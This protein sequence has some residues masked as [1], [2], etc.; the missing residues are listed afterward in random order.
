MKYRLSLVSAL[1]LAGALFAATQKSFDKPLSK[2]QKVEHALNRLT[3]GARPGDVEAIKR[4]GVDK[5]IQQQLHPEKIAENPELL[6]RLEQLP[7]LTMSS[8][9]AADR[10]EVPL[11][12]LQALQNASD[13]AKQKTKQQLKQQG[14]GPQV[15]GRELT[16]AKLLRAIYSERQL[17]ELMVDFWF[18]HFNVNIA[19]GADRMLVPS[20]ERDAIRPH[21]W[22]SFRDL[23][24]ATAHHPAMLFYL[25]NWQ[26]ATPEPQGRGG[27]VLRDLIQAKAKA[28]GKQLS[29]GINENYARELLELHTLGVDNGYTQQ[30]IIDVAKCFT[31]WTI[32]QPRQGGEFEFNARNH[33]S[34]P[35]TVLGVKIPAGGGEKDGEKVLDILAKRPETAQF[36]SFKLAQR[37]VADDP[38]QKLVD[39]MAKK[40]RDTDGDLRAVVETMITSSEFFSEAA[41][42]AKVKTP[43]EFVAS[44]VRATDAEVRNPIP[45]A[46][47]LNDMGQ[48]LYRKVE[49]TGY[50][51]MAAEWMNS[52]ALL[53]RVNFALDL[54]SG[55][56]QAVRL[57]PDNK[58]S[59]E[60]LGSPEFQRR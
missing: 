7:T 46:Q 21:V 43:L 32:R 31:G 13:D 54:S 29:R 30:D 45:L 6:A 25:D 42:N 18:N 28:K 37:F 60:T 48:P 47:R 17:D 55:R 9:E 22:G 15:V 3:F 59:G 19:K 1:A 33:D 2:D 14:K 35:K 57:S 56:L 39:R 38:P 41:L 34:G 36:I 16:E 24:G 58:V 11:D 51:S 49:P 40:F 52:A 10:F 23:L 8:R 50:S 53:A 20:Y 44:A 12:Q 5:W 27:N 26:N 4:M